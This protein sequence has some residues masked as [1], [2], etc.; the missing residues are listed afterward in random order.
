MPW[1]PLTLGLMLASGWGGYWL[2]GYQVEAASVLPVGSLPRLEYLSSPESFSRIVN[3]R[4]ALEALCVRV[5]LEAEHRLV[6]IAP[7]SNS[8]PPA[9]SLELAALISELQ[10]GVN[11][12]EGP[13]QALALAQDLLMALKTANRFD[14]WTDLYLKALY[15]HPTN[16][17]VARFATDAVEMA[18]KAG[19]EK[20]VLSGFSHVDEIPFEFGGKDR[21]RAALFRARG[22][23]VSSPREATPLGR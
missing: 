11:E 4:S 16:A 22:S 6:K 8:A 2:R 15:E 1:L 12:F 13:D 17:L 10:R 9:A 3:T 21:I 7:G 14:L 19:R 23:G 18:R 5:R 20:D